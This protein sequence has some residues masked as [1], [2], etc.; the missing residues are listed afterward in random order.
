MDIAVVKNK[1]REQ[2]GRRKAVGLKLSPAKLHFEA[3]PDKNKFTSL[4]STALGRIS[5]R[6][7]ETLAKGM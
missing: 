4:L 2:V 7:G 3:E 5:P 1:V 6:K